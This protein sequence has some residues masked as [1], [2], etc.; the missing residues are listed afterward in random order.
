MWIT[1]A[2]L[3]AFFAGITAILAKCGI[4]KTDSDVATAIRTIV[5]LIFSF[6]MTFITGSISDIDKIGLKSFVFLVLSGIATG[7]SWLCYY[8]AIQNAVVSVVVPIG[9]LSIIVSI[10]FSYI[11]FKEKLSK[12]SFAGLCLMTVGTLVMAIF[13]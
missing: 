5:V 8:Y 7:A 4:K 2:V 10:L 13:A 1:A 11:V 12:K 9:K 6:I 3:S